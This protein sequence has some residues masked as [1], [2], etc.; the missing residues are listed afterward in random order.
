MTFRVCIAPQKKCEGGGVLNYGGL[1][2][3]IF[4]HAKGI[5]WIV[6]KNKTGAPFGIPRKVIMQ[7]AHCAAMNSG[8]ALI[9]KPLPL[10]RAKFN[11][12][13]ASLYLQYK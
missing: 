3:T 11:K 12:T 7:C 2:K 8:C 6:K 10:L 9:V 13:W 5:A 1:E 4:L